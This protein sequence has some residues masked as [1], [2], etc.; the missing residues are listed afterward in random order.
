LS[1]RLH[2]AR[3]RFGFTTR[4]AS[5][6]AFSPAVALHALVQSPAIGP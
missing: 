2:A 4:S 5:T 1:G 3:A 6:A